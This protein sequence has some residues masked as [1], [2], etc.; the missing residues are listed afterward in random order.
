MMAW[1]TGS[2]AQTPEQ[3]AA[4][5]AKKTKTEKDKAQIDLLA[6]QAQ[7]AL[8]RKAH[9]RD[10]QSKTDEVKR[11]AREDKAKKQ[12]VKLFDELFSGS[13]AHAP[14]RTAKQGLIESKQAAVDEANKKIASQRKP[15]TRL[16]VDFINNGAASPKNLDLASGS[17]E[18][19][20]VQRVREHMVREPWNYVGLK[21]GL[22]AKTHNA[23]V[24]RV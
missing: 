1:L 16:T 6:K 15:F 20:E 3:I 18:R 14:H 9:V 12:G 19:D 24:K 21:T 2:N 5:A 23:A 22:F 13:W 4:D 8:A 10:V 7:D 17:R 11:K